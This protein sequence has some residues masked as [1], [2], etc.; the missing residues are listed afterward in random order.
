M[1]KLLNRALNFAILPLKL[2]ITEVLV[3]Y[4]KYAR[5]AIWHE[6]WHGKERQEEYEYSKPIFKHQKINLPKNYSSPPGLKI[7]LNSIKSEIMDPRNRNNEKCNLPQD[8]IDALKQLVKLQRERKITIRPCDKGAGIVILDFNI[9]MR[10]CYDHLL[11]KQPN[12]T[13]PMEEMS[14]YTKKK[15]NLHLTEQKNT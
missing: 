7:F 15:M 14:Y 12:Q 3:D 8:E 11:S 10:A 4:N 6:Y 9:Y 13:N 2:D 5:A 1:L